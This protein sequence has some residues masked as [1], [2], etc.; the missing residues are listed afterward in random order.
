MNLQ[1]TSY[2]VGIILIVFVTACTKG[3]S[4]Q[5]RSQVTYSGDFSEL[6]RNPDDYKD[7]IVLLG[8]KIIDTKV[9]ADSSEIIVLQLP[10]GGGDR[11]DVGDQSMGRFVIR[12]KQLLDPALYRKGMAI[13]V[14]GRLVGNETR[15]I[16][17]FKYNYPVIEPMEVKLWSED[18]YGGPSVHFGFGVLKSF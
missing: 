18:K 9:N 12:S 13:T 5:A 6:Q 8:G 17:E 3:I 1:K 10:L 14:V 16:D 15:T 11:P 4:K 7:E 2:L